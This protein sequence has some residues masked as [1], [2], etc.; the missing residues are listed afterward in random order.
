MLS[1]VR[2]AWGKVSSAAGLPRRA[3][4]KSEAERAH[5]WVDEWHFSSKA[6]SSSG[7]SSE[8]IWARASMS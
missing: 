4:S 5:R 7:K 6:Y 3:P 2:L 8:L 1:K